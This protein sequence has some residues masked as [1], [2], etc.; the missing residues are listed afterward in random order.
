MKRRKTGARSGLTSKKLRAKAVE[1]TARSL[2]NGLLTLEADDGSTRVCRKDR[3]GG[4]LYGDRVLAVPAGGDQAI[5]RRVLVRAN[6]RMTGLLETGRRH[7]AFSPMDRRLPRWIDVDESP[8][9]VLAATGAQAGDLVRARVVR[10]GD[11]GGLLVSIEER[12]GSLS[13]ASVA[14]DAL[15]ES[16]DLPTR[17]DEAAL[18]QADACR[19]ANLADD[20][21]REDLRDLIL[22]TIDGRDAKDFDDAVSVEDLGE[23]RLRLGVH[24][25]DVGHYVPQG[26]PLDRVAFARGTSVYLPGRVLPMLP[27]ALSNGVCSL[28]PD[29]DKFALSAFV[30]LSPEGRPR[31]FRLTRTISRSRARLV[32]DDVNAMFDG[33]EAQAARMDALGVRESL[34]SMRT[35]ARAI[36]RRREAQGCVDFELDEPVFELGEDG[37]PVSIALRARGEAERMIEDFMLTANERVAKLARERGLPLLYRVHERPDPE[38]LAD[39]AA[40]LGRIGVNAGALKHGAAPGDLRAILEGTRERPEYPVIA[41][42][43][44]R[45]MSKA[46]YDAHPLG[47]YGLAMRDYCHFTSPIRRYPDLVVS[48]ALTAMLAGKKVT[49]TGD[50]LEQAARVSSDR[51]RLAADA[52][53]TAD[54]LMAAH[55][56]ADHIGEVF[57]G[58]IAGVSAH[59]FYVALGNGAEGFVS[60]RTLEDWFEFDERR[61]TLCGERTGRTFSLGQRLRV[62]VMDA[63][64]ATGEIDLEI[65]G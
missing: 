19:P 27:E 47:H 7:A 11:E 32:Y 59:G 31:D 51:E 4:A 61:M 50:A 65:C 24:I 13:R 57:D 15:I 42:L 2:R 44:L 5:V 52:E 39:F 12:L 55:V 3:A 6:E 1:M 18:A 10:W 60:V 22:F 40:F 21:G 58:S 26:T 20:P 46:R 9:D 35:L 54:K 38:K 41:A 28:R 53:R 29:E 49:L 43:A 36:R 34:L 30:T 63:R 25:A 23:G 56:M 33:D 64:P 17:F 45:S 62:R 48:R 8:A 16:L 37:E 14:L